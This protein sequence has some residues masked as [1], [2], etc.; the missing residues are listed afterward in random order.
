[1]C[2]MASRRCYLA[3]LHSP[4]IILLVPQGFK[5]GEIV[6]PYLGGGG[7]V[8]SKGKSIRSNPRP[9]ST[10]AQRSLLLAARHRLRRY[11]SEFW[12]KA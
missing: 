12:D 6:G 10:G 4:L 1:M 3:S 5:C 8:V 7:G 9:L 2:F 11:A